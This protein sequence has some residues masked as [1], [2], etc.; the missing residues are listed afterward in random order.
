MSWIEAVFS[1][2]TL[3]E[4]IQ[5]AEALE[6]KSGGWSRDVLDCLAKKSPTSLHLAHRLWK[7]GR[8]LD[9]SRALDMEYAVVANLL[10]EGDF[11]EG[12]RAMI[13]DKDKAPRWEPSD[14]A[15]VTRDRID[16][17]MQNRWGTLDLPARTA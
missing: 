8:S 17:L 11:L 13:I 4:I 6:E 14:I 7:K 5:R 16:H 2:S 12:I 15:G 1:A 9:L 3:G 10:R